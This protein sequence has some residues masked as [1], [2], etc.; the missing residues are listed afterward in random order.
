M[1]LGGIRRGR[2][3]LFGSGASLGVKSGPPSLL[4]HVPYPGMRRRLIHSNCYR[5]EPHHDQN[6]GVCSAKCQ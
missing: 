4:D 2:V 5:G 1:A 3:G 6:E